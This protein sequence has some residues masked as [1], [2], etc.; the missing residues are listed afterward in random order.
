MTG[1]ISKPPIRSVR[2]GAIRW[3]GVEL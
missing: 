2:S 1:L 3:C